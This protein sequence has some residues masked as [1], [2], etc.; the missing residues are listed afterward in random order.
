M[1]RDTIDWVG[2][3]PFEVASPGELL[4]FCRD[5]G[6]DLEMLRTVGGRHGCNEFVL[7][8]TTVVMVTTISAMVR[9]IAERWS[10]GAP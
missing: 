7:V 4:D 2:G 3:L 8:P 9:A 10:D 1:Y 6:L 5:R